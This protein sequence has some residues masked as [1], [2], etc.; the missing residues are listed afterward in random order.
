MFAEGFSI[1]TEYNSTDPEGENLS[2][3]RS[4]EWS[5]ENAHHNEKEQTE[6]KIQGRAKSILIYKH[7]QWETCQGSYEVN[8]TKK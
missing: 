8:K 2:V 5:D 6:R 3:H 1:C 4:D 7:N